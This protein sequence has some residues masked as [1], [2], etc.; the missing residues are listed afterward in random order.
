MMPHGQALRQRARLTLSVHLIFAAV[1]HVWLLLWAGA[2]HG[3]EPLRGDEELHRQDQ[4]REEL[5]RRQEGAPDVRLQARPS[6]PSTL[7]PDKETPCRRI[8]VVRPR[9]MAPLP[10]I[11][12][13]ALAG[14]DGKDAPTN[15]CLG[16][17][18]I[19]VLLQRATNALVESGYVT[20]TVEALPQDLDAGELVLTIHPGLIG[21]IRYAQ[22]DGGMSP[23][24]ASLAMRPGGVLNLRDIEQSLENLR[25]NAGAD[26][27]ITIEPGSSEDQSIIV[28][29]YQRPRPFGLTLTLDD[30]GGEATGRWQSSATFTWNSPL[31]LSDLFY[32]SGSKHALDNGHK[33]YHG[34]SS[35]MVHYSVP[36]GYWLVSATA[37]SS[38]HDQTL[39]GGLENRYSGKSETGELQVQRVLHRGA[40]SKSAWGLKAFWR[41]SN[42]FINDE[43][44]VS[45]RRR[46]GG[47]E[48]TAS[49]LHYLGA[50]TLDA[51]LSFRRGTGAFGAVPA[52]EQAS[53]EGTSRMRIV[54]GNVGIWMPF[55]LGSL[56]PI[57]SGQ[58]RVQWNAAPV[59]AQDRLCIGGR[60]SVRGF[61]GEQSL[62]ASRGQTLRNEL[63][64]PI[65]GMPALQGYGGL[66]LGGVQGSTALDNAW[67]AGAV[68]GFRWSGQ[69]VLGGVVQ[70]DAFVGRPLHK[71]E[72]FQTART[73]AGLSI[74]ASF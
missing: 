56:A 25:R 11:V 10:D 52:Y 51:H 69:T 67:L 61:D 30:S 20:S 58:L 70:I 68:M 47:W 15:R 59:T 23:V 57:Y 65:F 27:D 33:P 7:L 29:R 3:Q 66:D 34:S 26:A 55:S 60:Y 12:N 9:G 41:Q 62:C 24:G 43:E 32:V 71:P 54:Q 21:D 13:A 5:R 19:G 17:Q 8:R 1:L 44:Q 37:S 74:S 50:G 53:G 22:R 63:A 48:I 28:I 2:T 73:S 36:I 72:S 64:L 38:N 16:T 18:G 6:T 39:P 49:H 35:Q 46:A 31:G 14:L 45:A 40:L 4:Q 42:N